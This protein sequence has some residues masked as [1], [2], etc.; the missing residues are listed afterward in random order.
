MSTATPPKPIIDAT[1]KVEDVKPTRSERYYDE[2]GD[3]ELL[4]SD[5]VLF[6]LHA[7]R[8]QASS[9]VIPTL[10]RVVG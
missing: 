7:Y 1:V 2:S 8:L 10:W 5:N 3:V 9:Y 6:K 4:S